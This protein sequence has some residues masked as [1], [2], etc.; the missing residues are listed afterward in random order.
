LAY[1]ACC[2]NL[3][4]F[5]RILPPPCL[6]IG[7]ESSRGQPL[8]GTQGKR[9]A[10]FALVTTVGPQPRPARSILGE[11]GRASDRQAFA[12]LSYPANR[13]IFR[14]PRVGRPGF[15]VS[16]SIHPRTAVRRGRHAGL[17]LTPNCQRWS[18]RSRRTVRP[19]QYVT[20]IQYVTEPGN[21]FGQIHPFLP[22]RRRP[23][24]DHSLVAGGAQRQG[25]Q[26]G[27]C[28]TLSMG[29]VSQWGWCQTLFLVLT[30]CLRNQKQS[31]TPDDR[32]VGPSS[33]YRY[34]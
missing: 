13:Q 22:A 3:P 34:L 23:T 2:S 21:F 11:P 28:Q 1:V 32:Q 5:C 4:P 8:S 31:L 33:R 7:F 12:S 14:N 27:W 26:W 24:V 20:E 25:L 16:L 10:A 18:A 15:L 9:V 30:C 17:L 19:Y 29:M 6:P